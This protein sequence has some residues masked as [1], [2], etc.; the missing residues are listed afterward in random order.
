MSYLKD[1]FDQEI[2]GLTDS[3]SI[4]EPSCIASEQQKFQRFS[5]I[6]RFSLVQE[7]LYTL[8]DKELIVTLHSILKSSKEKMESLT[9]TTNEQ[10]NEITE[11]IEKSFE[12]FRRGF[13]VTMSSEDINEMK[14]FILMLT[15][16]RHSCQ[17][18]SKLF[19]QDY[20]VVAILEALIQSKIDNYFALFFGKTAI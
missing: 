5:P 9:S 4:L 18:I 3:F 19:R 10:L 13:N 12:H 7:F 16:E 1:L 20:R 11:G 17:K 8:D 2:E 14:S 15:S 6:C